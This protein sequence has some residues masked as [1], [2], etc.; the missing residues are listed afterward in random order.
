MPPNPLEKITTPEFDYNFILSQLS[1][2]RYPRDRISD[3]LK[4]GDMIRVKKGIYV[5]GERWRQPAST[6]LLA[7]MIYGP[8][9]VSMEYALSYYGLIPERVVEVTSV[10]TGK[11]KEF[12][13]PLG[14]FTYLHQNLNIYQLGFRRIALDEQRGFLIATPEKALADRVKRET[15]S[16]LAE[17][18]GFLHDGLRIEKRSLRELK[19]SALSAIAKASDHK[20]IR[21][22]NECIARM[23]S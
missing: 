5:L 7:N 2:Y 11:T 21:L 20:S 3:L 1:E 14:L 17:M 6:P 18:K 12:Q 13:T 8:S 16:S 9:Y 4:K 22:L 23:K 15:L 19:R 10:T